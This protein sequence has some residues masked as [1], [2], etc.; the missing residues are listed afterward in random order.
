MTVKEYLKDKTPTQI[1]AYERVRDIVKTMVPDMEEVMSYGI[2]TFKHKGK[3]VLYF[4]A[5]PNHMSLYGP[6]QVVEKEIEA[7]G[8]KTS[9]KGT[10]QFSDD[11]PIP[12]SMIRKMAQARIDAIDQK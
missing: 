11:K 10:V 1:A 12:E 5:Y 7:A 4:G 2:I 9:K 6:V 3:Y 8:F